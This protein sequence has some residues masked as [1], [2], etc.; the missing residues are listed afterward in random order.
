M[1]A[2][3]EAEPGAPTVD[4][5]EPM[6]ERSVR[7]TVTRR[8]RP[9][10][11]VPA[12]IV[13]LLLAVVAVLAIIEI[14]SY[15]LNS[16][17]GVFPATQLARLGRETLWNDALTLVVAAVTA[18]VGLLLLWLAFWPGRVRA[19][20]LAPEHPGVAVAITPDDL[21][22]LAGEAAASVSGVD[23]V[24]VHVRRGQINVRADSPLHDPAGVDEE[25][26]QAVGERV[27]QLQLQ[28]P[29]RVRVHL[30]HREG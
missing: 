11:R 25:I 21:R 16:P 6:D 3:N 29:P 15:L 13:A 1:T 28:Q 22:R 8:F 30:R 9:R 24:S 2:V 19:A 7:R 23:R 26:R 17:L 4:H 5:R 27:D 12:V 10:R 20:A 18:L 14:V